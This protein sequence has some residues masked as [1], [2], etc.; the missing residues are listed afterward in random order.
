MTGS[1]R[2]VSPPHSR[3]VLVCHLNRRHLIRRH[4]DHEHAVQWKVPGRG[5]CRGAVLVIK[6]LVNFLTNLLTNFTA[7][8]ARR[9]ADVLFRALVGRAVRGRRHA[10]LRVGESDGEGVIGRSTWCTSAGTRPLVYRDL[11]RSATTARGF[12][13]QSHICAHLCSSVVARATGRSVVR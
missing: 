9:F 1:L 6:K 12:T 7:N 11:R 4:P 2:F 10:L 13:L 5:N 3:L 8:F